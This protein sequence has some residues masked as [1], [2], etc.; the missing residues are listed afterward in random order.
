MVPETQQ[1][2]FYNVVVVVVVMAVVTVPTSRRASFPVLPVVHLC[3]QRRSTKEVW[4][5]GRRPSWGPL[6]FERTLGLRRPVFD[7]FRWEWDS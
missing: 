1:T 3:S 5:A 7:P 6:S 4:S 2:I